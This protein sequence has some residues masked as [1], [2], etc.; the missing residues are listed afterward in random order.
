VVTALPPSQIVTAAWINR[1]ALG[2]LPLS[3]VA[4]KAVTLVER[5]N[6]RAAHH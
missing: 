2:K 5:R 1:E 6:V 3:T 4:K